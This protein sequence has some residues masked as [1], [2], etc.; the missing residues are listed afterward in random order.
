MTRAEADHLVDVYA[1]SIAA[2]SGGLLQTYLAKSFVD[3]SD[4]INIFIHRP[5]GPPPPP[6]LNP[7]R[8]SSRSS[9]RG[10]TSPSRSS[11]WRC[12]GSRTL[13]GCGCRRRGLTILKTVWE[14][15]IWR[16]GEIVMEYNALVWLLNIGGSYTWEGETYTGMEP[17]AAKLPHVYE[18]DEM[19]E[20][21]EDVAEEPVEEGPVEDGGE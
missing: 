12:S 18:R 17:G 2:F 21:G 11:P 7:R 19:A 8:S 1:R 3:V 5:L 15:G 13:G 10:P 20:P 9:A 16:V 6:P 14:S 4:S